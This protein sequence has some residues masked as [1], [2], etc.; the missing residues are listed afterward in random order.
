MNTRD[1]R[2]GE[3]VKMV[4]DNAINRLNKINGNDRNALASEYKEWIDKPSFNDDV[5]FSTDK[6]LS[7][8]IE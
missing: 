8:Y 2:A 1:E 4:L 3:I 6:N 7:D 5:W